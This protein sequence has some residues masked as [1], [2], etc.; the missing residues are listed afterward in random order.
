MATKHEAVERAYSVLKTVG[1]DETEFNRYP[2]ELSGGQKQRVAIA[3][4]LALEANI[5]LMDE[6]FSAIDE[7]SKPSLRMLLLDIAKREE[8]TIIIVSHSS[9]DVH[10]LAD[11][12][13]CLNK[14]N[15]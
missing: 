6:P 1:I 4:G 5:L 12:I 10:C 14:Q 15:L 11:R 2:C 13:I 8:K 9:E 7:S 3:R